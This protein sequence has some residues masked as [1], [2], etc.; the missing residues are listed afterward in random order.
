MLKHTVEVCEMQVYCKTSA[1]FP[2]RIIAFAY[3]WPLEEG[4]CLFL[5]QNLFQN[6]CFATVR[7]QWN[8]VIHSDLQFTVGEVEG[9]IPW[10]SIE[11]LYIFFYHPHKSGKWRLN[12]IQACALISH[13]SLLLAMF[14]AWFVPNSREYLTQVHCPIAAQLKESSLSLDH[15]AEDK[16]SASWGGGLAQKTDYRAVVHLLLPPLNLKLPAREACMSSRHNII[17]NL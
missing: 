7:P 3:N 12:K 2:F 9:E 16:T 1:R 10:C 6:C 8:P 11:P 13:L 4:K 17:L 15:T 5:S 14:G